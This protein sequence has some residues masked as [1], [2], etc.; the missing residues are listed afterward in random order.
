MSSNNNSG[1]TQRKHDIS[2][3]QWLMQAWQI[4]DEITAL[5]EARDHAKDRCLS[6]TVKYK[7]PVSGNSGGSD[8]GL[9]SLVYLEQ[10][11]DA[12]IDKLCEVKTDILSAINQLDDGRYRQLL[13]GRYIQCKTWEQVAVDMHYS[14]KQVCRLHGKALVAIKDVLVCPIA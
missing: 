3:K 4:D 1:N 9:V 11:I 10:K 5:L 14:Y 12:R 8:D 6:V 7:E 2:P 13:I